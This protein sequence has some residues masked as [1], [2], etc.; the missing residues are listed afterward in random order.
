MDFMEMMKDTNNVSVTEN[1]ALGYKTTKHAL[2]DMHF[3]LS[4]MR[5]MSDADIIKLWIPAYLGNKTLALRWL[6]YIRDIRGGM[7]ERRVFR[8]IWKYLSHYDPQVVSNIVRWRSSFTLRNGPLVPYFG[9]WDDLISMFQTP[10][11]GVAIILICNQLKQDINAMHEGKSISLLAKWCPSINAGVVAHKHAEKIRK[12]MGLSPKGYKH[13]LSSLRKYLDV[14]EVKASKNNWNEIDY[15]KVPSVA[16]VK[17]AKP[18]LRHDETR[19]REYLHEVTSGKKKINSSVTFPYEIYAKLNLRSTYIKDRYQYDTEVAPTMNELWKALPDTING[20]DMSTLVVCDSSGSMVTPIGSSNSVQAIDVSE[21]LA[22]YFAERMS[23]P[24]ADKFVT[25]SRYPEIVDIPHD[26]TLVE[27]AML[28]RSKANFENTDIARVFQLILDTAVQN[29]CSQ[30]DIPKN[31]LIISDMEFD[32]LCSNDEQKLFE[33]LKYEYEEN[34]YQLPRLIFWN[35]NSRT[36]TIPLT[37][38]ENGVAL[39]S[40]FSPNTAKMVMSD[41]LDAYEV[42]LEQLMNPRYQ[43]I[44]EAMKGGF[45][46]DNACDYNCDKCKGCS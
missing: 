33:Y 27:K 39:V 30:G 46:I 1:G 4:S 25:F 36:G 8:V 20:Q 2:L 29:G 3:Q 15:E 43:V 37:E 22:I 26:L 35:V 41:K 11:E 42:L 21:S 44:E 38:N 28:V 13:M 19:R 45:P 5:S 10:V 9:R 7:G 16:N 14:L 34:G 18:F 32:Y 23:G 24:F 40:G 6:F 17:Y 12:A 31:V